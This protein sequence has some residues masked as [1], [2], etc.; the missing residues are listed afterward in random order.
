M[1]WWC[2]DGALVCPFSPS[3]VASQR[4]KAPLLAGP[5]WAVTQVFFLGWHFLPLDDFRSLS[6]CQS[7]PTTFPDP[8]GFPP[9]PPLPPVPQSQTLSL[10]TLAAPS[11]CRLRFTPFSSICT[12]YT[13]LG[14]PTVVPL[15][16]HTAQSCSFFV[17]W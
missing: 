5:D 10:A 1:A 3:L 6:S 2:P 14:F 15:L 17:L 8:H 12:P 4:P 16:H 13:Y 7:S 11:S 9:V